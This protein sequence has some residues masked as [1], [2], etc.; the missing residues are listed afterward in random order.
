MQLHAKKALVWANTR[1]R[2]QPER[3]GLHDV[4]HKT[5][6]VSELPPVND[7]LYGIVTWNI[8]PVSGVLHLRF[9]ACSQRVPKIP[10][11]GVVRHGIGYG[12]VELYGVMDASRI[13]WGTVAGIID[14]GPEVGAVW[15]RNIGWLQGQVIPCHTVSEFFFETVYRKLAVVDGV[16][17]IG[18][19][20]I[21]Q[22]RINEII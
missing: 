10:E 4:Y 21:H 15:T 19:G 5:N 17:G 13:Q 2:N 11:Q 12:T 14:R 1:I 9:V 20:L 6:G 22:D 8:I 18:K 7:V 16:Y 3:W